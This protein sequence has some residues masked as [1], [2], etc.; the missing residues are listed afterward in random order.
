MT[1]VNSAQ[2]SHLSCGSTP[3]VSHRSV[4]DWG[5][6]LESLAIAQS[7]CTLYTVTSH[8]PAA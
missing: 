7:C 6:Q 1:A 8:L 4:G 3:S 5:W 2:R